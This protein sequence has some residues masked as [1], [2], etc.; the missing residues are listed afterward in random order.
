MR[1]DTSQK[2]GI[3]GFAGL[4]I[5]TKCTLF[6]TFMTWTLLFNH[7][8][9]HLV[10]T[11]GILAVCRGT[12]ISPGQ[13]S[14]RLFP[15]MPLLIMMPLFTGFT[16][17]S[18]VLDPQNS[19]VLLSLG[20]HLHLYR[21]GLLLGL[22]FILRLVNMVIFSLLILTTTPLDDIITLLTRLRLPRTLSFVIT[23][24][25]RFVPE[26]DRRRRMIT[27]AQRAR[28]ID[29]DG[30]GPLKRFRSAVAVMVPLIVN[31]ILVADQLTI[32]LMNRGFGYCNHWTVPEG[33]RLKPGDYGVLLVCLAGLT[34]AVWIRLRTGWAR[35]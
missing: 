30:G 6:I 19:R 17:P 20:E 11:A 34:T 9:C 31:G 29:L 24:A 5:R 22:T 35:L 27:Q 32:A 3:S 33:Q 13:V 10:M 25:I 18:P 4:D 2:T 26:L 15:L 28:G 1:P 7:P 16:L 21:G 23:T 12:D 8:G 14:K